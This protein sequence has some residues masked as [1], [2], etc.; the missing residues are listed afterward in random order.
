LAINK[1]NLAYFRNLIE[2]YQIEKIEMAKVSATSLCFIY[3]L[4]VFTASYFT[5]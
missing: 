5:K 4:F 3:D 1:K 2:K